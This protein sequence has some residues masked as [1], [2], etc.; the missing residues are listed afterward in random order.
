MRLQGLLVDVLPCALLMGMTVIELLRFRRTGEM[1]AASP[2]IWLVMAVLLLT[3][4]FVTLAGNERMVWQWRVLIKGAAVALFVGYLAAVA[5]DQGPYGGLPFLHVLMIN[6][7]LLL[8]L[9]RMAL[10]LL[11][12]LTS[13][14]LVDGGYWVMDVIVGTVIMCV[15]S[16]MC[17]GGVISKLQAVLMFGSKYIW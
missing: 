7:C 3:R 16:I 2:A 12:P 1:L 15:L 4:P 10:H 6:T 8:A 14:S 9:H 5:I 17:L 13:A 11:P